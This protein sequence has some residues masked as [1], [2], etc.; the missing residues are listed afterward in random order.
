MT[1]KLR[2][3][4]TTKFPHNFFVWVGIDGSRIPAMLVNDTYNGSMD[5]G[6]IA[7]AV[8]GGVREREVPYAYLFGHGDGG[9]GGP[10]VEMLELLRYV[11]E[12]AG[13]AHTIFSEE[14]ML[15]DVLQSSGSAEE[16]HGELYVENH[17]GGTYTTNSRVKKMVSRLE[18]LLLA[19]D[20]VASLQTIGGQ[21]AGVDT[22]RD[23]WEAL[24]TAQFHDVIPGSANYFAY[25]EAFA[26]L[27]KSLDRVSKFIA[28]QVSDFSGRRGLAGGYIVLNRSRYGISAVL[29]ASSDLINLTGEALGGTW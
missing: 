9:G 29:D 5:Y 15:C 26:D 12:I 11:H 3:N 20:F 8:S 7:R 4:D 2:W 22:L 18:D 1:H 10:S 24:L 21:R 13:G 6:E 17:R 19:A 25:S 27:G 23:D 16:V 14:E 28:D